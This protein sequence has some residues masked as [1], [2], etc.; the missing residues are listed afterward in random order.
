MFSGTDKALRDKHYHRLIK[1]YH[2]TLSDTIQQLG[3]NANK[4]FPF[5]AMM[6]NF[7]QFGVF[8]YLAMP[9]T[10][11]IVVASSDESTTFYEFP[12]AD[13]EASNK[14]A[15]QFQL[16]ENTLNEYIRRMTDITNDLF[17]LGMIT[18]E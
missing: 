6:E 8:T 15:N 2:D 3:S 17:D 10:V 14:D 1:L 5:D 18:I 11:D 7:K 4:L 12:D 16:G 9:I 13:S